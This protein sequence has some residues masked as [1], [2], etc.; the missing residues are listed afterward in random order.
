MTLYWSA[1]GVEH[2]RGMVENQAP[3]CGSKYEIGLGWRNESGGGGGWVIGGGSKQQEGPTADRV[4]CGQTCEDLPNNTNAT[5]YYY[6]Y[7]Y[8]Y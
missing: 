1:E 7:Y 2:N 8:F 6:Y 5:Y 4:T 3:V